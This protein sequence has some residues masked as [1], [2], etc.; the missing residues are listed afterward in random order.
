MKP[1][2]AIVGPTA[3]G[4]TALSIYLAKQ[5]Q[6]QILCM[7]SMQVYRGMDIGTAKPTMAERE[8]IPHHMLDVVSPK[9]PY[10][11]AE[12]VEGAKACIETIHANGQVPILVGGT[13]L[14]LKA[15]SGGL[16][17]GG[18]V[19]N[20]GLRKKLEA[21][22]SSPEGKNEL[23]MQLAKVD[24]AAAARLHVNDS[25]RVIRALEV[26]ELT[27]RPLSE[28]TQQKQ[29]CPYHL[30]TLGV[31][32]ERPL[33]IDRINRRVDQMLADGLIKEVQKL[34]SEGVSPAAQSMQ[35]LGYKELAPYLLGEIPLEAAVEQIKIG[36]R[37][38]AKRQMTWF[39]R[40]PQVSWL[41]GQD[42]QTPVKALKIVH[43]QLQEAKDP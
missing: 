12:Y 31:G 38:Y 11:V 4:K 24:P 43:D 3:S 37:Q 17:L 21:I 8:G 14:Y 28:Q 15:L 7:D 22:A 13:G 23:H 29:L 10:S 18:T 25:R 27:G 19:G 34:L 33:L 16:T 2:I 41:D 5:L 6:T 20:E 30:I 39:R 35:G 1:V 26:F 36:T 9:E 32:M 40:T 42:T